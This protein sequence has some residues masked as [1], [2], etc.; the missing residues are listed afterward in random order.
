[1]TPH[2]IEL[3]QS[4]F[5]LVQPIL[6]D[7]V[8]LFYD[9]LFSLD[10]S[11]ESTFNSPRAEQRRKLAQMLTMVVKGID[12]PERIRG[13]VQALGS[14]HVA[15]GVRDEHYTTVGAALLWT[16]EKG[17][18][19][20]FTSDVRG[21]WSAAYGWLAFTMRE[22]AALSAA[23]AESAASPIAAAV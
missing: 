21:A 15:Y 16:L 14:R 13:A 23:A 4:S 10:P 6:D 3:V 22:A 7:A 8:V 20:A 17:L 19:R 1:M 11:L 18:G 5:R 2:Q 9:R 12:H